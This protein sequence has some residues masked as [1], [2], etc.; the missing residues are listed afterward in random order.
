VPFGSGVFFLTAGATGAILS[1]TNEPKKNSRPL[2]FTGTFHLDIPYDPTLGGYGWALAM[3]ASSE[4]SAP[5][6]P[7]STDAGHTLQLQSVTLPDGTPVSV[8]FDTGLQL[9]S[10]PEPST[11][12]LSVISAVGCLVYCWLRR[13]PSM[14]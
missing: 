13:K 1:P 7:A 11:L 12:T 3:I 10:V 6:G 9:S 14:I 2:I 5:G 8:T 4:V